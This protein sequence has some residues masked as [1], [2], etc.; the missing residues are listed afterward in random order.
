MRPFKAWQCL[1][2]THFLLY[3][4]SRPTC[5]HFRPAVQSAARG[6]NRTGWSVKHVSFDRMVDRS[7]FPVVRMETEVWDLDSRT[8]VWM[9]CGPVRESAVGVAFSPRKDLVACLEASHCSLLGAISGEMVVRWDST[10]HS[11]Q[12]QTNLAWATDDTRLLTCDWAGIIY[13][14]DVASAMA[15]KRV[16]LVFHFDTRHDTMVCSFTDGHRCITT[17]HGVFSIPPSIAHHAPQQ[18]SSLILRTLLRLRSDA[19]SGVSE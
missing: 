10:P 3:A 2:T 13:V 14:W 6:L 16:D 12:I 5:P 17:D 11:S 8:R 1:Q 15:S 19:G 4:V 18:T 7:H 9:Y